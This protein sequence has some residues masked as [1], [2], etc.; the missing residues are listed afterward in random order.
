MLF[1]RNK[2]AL[3]LLL[4]L[5]IIAFILSWHK[6]HTLLFWL[7]RFAELVCC[8][9]TFR[10]LASRYVD[11]VTGGLAADELGVLVGEPTATA[12]VN[13]LRGLLNSWCLSAVWCSFL[14]YEFSWCRREFVDCLCF[15]SNTTDASR[16]K[17]IPLSLSFN[18]SP[19]Q[20][21]PSPVIGLFMQ[22]NIH[23]NAHLTFWDC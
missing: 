12:V 5:L 7:V 10:S 20:I 3:A 18:R 17:V 13:S 23:C 19:Y 8:F 15:R 9:A 4:L 2:V 16:S 6:I 1:T 22:P 21:Q 11:G 14:L